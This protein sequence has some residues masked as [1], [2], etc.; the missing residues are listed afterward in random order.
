MLTFFDL[1][2]QIHSRQQE[3]Q[4]R[5]VRAQLWSPELTAARR[6]AGPAQLIATFLAAIQQPLA[7][8]G[9]SRTAQIAFCATC[10]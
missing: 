3:L 4:R 6:S 2:T 10:A 8:L 9:V 1:E 5:A 7:R